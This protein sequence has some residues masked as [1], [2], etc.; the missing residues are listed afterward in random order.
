MIIEYN[1]PQTIEEALKLLQ[2]SDPK[3]VPMGG[4]SAI[5]KPSPE[6]LAVVDLQALG[7]NG[8]SVQ[9]NLVQLGATLS[10]QTLLDQLEAGDLQ[11]SRLAPA[12]AQ[13]V[14]HEATY[15]LRQTATVAGTLVAADGR[16][17]FATALL[18]LDAGLVVLPGEETLSLGD[19]LPLRQAR[20]N[21]RLIT[22]VSLPGNASLAYESVA[23]TPADRPIVCAAV[24][25]W[26]SGR[27]R[28]ALGGF[29][30]C[31]T[32]AMDGTE[33]EGAETAARNACSQAGD[34]W[35][36]AEYRQEVAATLVKRCLN[37]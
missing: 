13:V 26:P 22:Q 11:S 2:R 10:L 14:T 23:R 15:N 16:S 37:A 30:A 28:V 17:P 32:L 36:S 5:N 29:G 18:A 7:L 8:L 31:P 1:R 21:G 27:T 20:L 24:A 4:G 33:A 6:A 25:T 9:G 3:T 34:Q 35:A 12:L 19:V